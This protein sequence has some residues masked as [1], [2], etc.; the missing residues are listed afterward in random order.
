MLTSLADA[1]SRN[2]I[3]LPVSPALWLVLALSGGVVMF[4]LGWIIRAQISRHQKNTL[5]EIIQASELRLS[6]MKR[7]LSQQR[8][9]RQDLTGTGFTDHT[10]SH[11]RSEEHEATEHAAV[12]STAP[13]SS[14]PIALHPSET[15]HQGRDTAAAPAPPHADLLEDSL[16]AEYPEFSIGG[17][18]SDNLGASPGQGQEQDH[19]RT[20]VATPTEDGIPVMAV[21]PDNLRVL[22]KSYEESRRRHTEELVAFK[23]SLTQLKRRYNAKITAQTDALAAQEKESS[24]KIETLN[25]TVARNKNRVA[26]LIAEVERYKS[27]IEDLR[28]TREQYESGLKHVEQLQQRITEL[29]ADNQGY[30]LDITRLKSELKSVQLKHE[31]A[32]TDDRA[33]ASVRHSDQGP[34]TATH[35]PPQTDKNKSA[36]DDTDDL[37]QI[38]GIGPVLEKA[39]NRQGIHQFSQLAAFTDEDVERIALLINTSAKRIKREQWVAMAATLQHEKYDQEVT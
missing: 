20:L 24:A 10:L 39:L 21:K 31:T 19:D 25:H 33:L 27:V 26:G 32:S 28:Q 22:K 35:M 18:L 17:R 30:L 5:I 6:Q 14:L 9:L 7:R 8:E 3:S 16:N 13:D 2:L 11:N 12:N 34:V 4:L 37:K 38:K 1:L 29:T 15:T 36:S 23:T